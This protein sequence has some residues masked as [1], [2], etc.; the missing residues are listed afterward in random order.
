[1]RSLLVLT[2]LVACGKTVSAFASFDMYYPKVMKESWTANH[3]LL[4]INKWINKIYV[5]LLILHKPGPS[6][7]MRHSCSPSFAEQGGGRTGRQPSQLALAGK[8]C[9]TER[10]TFLTT[11]EKHRAMLCLNF[12]QK[13]GTVEPFSCS[14]NLLT[15][16]DHEL[17]DEMGLWGAGTCFDVKM[18]S[19]QI[20]L[21]SDS[22]GRWRHVC[23][24]T[25]ISSDWLLTAA[26]CIKYAF[27]GRLSV[28]LNVTCYELFKRESVSQEEA[29]WK[30]FDHGCL[31][32]YQDTVNVYYA[33][34]SFH[35]MFMK[36]F[37]VTGSNQRSELREKKLGQHGRCNYS[38][39]YNNFWIWERAKETYF[40]L[41]ALYTL[42]NTGGK[43]QKK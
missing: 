2:L 37:V 20:S 10:N 15:T 25:L 38:F 17:T 24:G 33:I 22:S 16:T 5:T 8:G 11:E 26:H 41:Y 12:P 19:F 39:G 36:A 40:I 35:F 21:Q 31:Q 42:Q 30:V 1:M 29:F 18:C 34:N 7:W 43:R 32:L 13:N 14:Q 23:G 27:G 4:K 3:V 6:Q 9:S 28:W